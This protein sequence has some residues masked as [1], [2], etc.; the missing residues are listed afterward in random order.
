MIDAD[1]RGYLKGA[2]GEE[3]PLRHGDPRWADT[4]LLAHRLIERS[5][6]E[7]AL[8]ALEQ[9]PARK[10]RWDLLLLTALLQQGLGE[11][12]R[13]LDALEVVADKLLAAGDRDGVLALL[14][15]FLE[16]EPNPAAVRFLHFLSQN[17]AASEEERA[18]WLRTAIRIRHADPELHADL[19]ALLERSTD[20]DAREAAREHRLRAMELSLEDGVHE[21]LSEALFRAVDEDLETAPVRIGKILLRYAA[22]AP[23]SDSESMLDLA[24]PPLE[25]R[26]KGR[27]AW[28]DVA[29]ILPRLPGGPAGRALFARLFRIVVG[30]EPD[31]EA[32]VQGSG[33]LDPKESFDAIA[34]RVPKILALPPGAYVTHQTWG[35]GRVLS[36]DGD[37]L[38]L[39]FT[40][41][42]GH[43]MSFAMAS[44]SL[45]RLPNDGLRVLA[46]QHPERARAL[47]SEGDP[48]V[49]AR[50]LRDMGGTATQAQM[51]PRLE[52][53]LPGFD[54]A[55]FW[56]KVKERWKAD[57]RL[58][59]SE[60]YRGQ[61]RLAPEGSEAAAA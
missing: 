55:V 54:A 32:I 23:W 21:G 30:R 42:T 22:V 26:A 27:F 34:A 58:D 52:A 14:P 56:K 44:R 37:S 41:R 40:G 1:L 19:A 33:I 13:A 57:P 24:M 35:V 9:E 20:P 60:A 49:I 8:K 36:S 48:E 43:K 45:D 51:K 46:I 61:F 38:T 47:A 7:A 15:R 59:T 31:P 18:D 17:P 29:P 10:K 2:T 5:A 39:D 4:E 28:D 53:A 16:P 3:P 11:R 6:A 25:E 12:A 50:V